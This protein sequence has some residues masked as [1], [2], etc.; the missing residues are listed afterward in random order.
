PEDGD[1]YVGL[2]TRGDGSFESIG[3]RL[4]HPLSNEH[5]YQFSIDLSF[6][7]NYSGYNN[8]LFLKIWISNK[9]GHRQQLIYKSP[10]IDHLEWKTYNVEFIPAE[11][12]QY[13]IIEAFISDERIPYK[14]NIL[15]DN[16][17]HISNCNRA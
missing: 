11:I 17:S 15:L 3:Q 5:C 4:S 16:M 14:G 1:S 6:S 9:R 2:I 12:S 8:P 13:I 7:D 10:K